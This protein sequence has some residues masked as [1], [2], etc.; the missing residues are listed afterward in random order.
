MILRIGKENPGQNMNAQAQLGLRCR[1][2]DSFV[3]LSVL[4][5]GASKGA[6]ISLL[7]FCLTLKKL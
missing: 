5:A 1:Y 4:I 2:M 6:P 7:C 3:A